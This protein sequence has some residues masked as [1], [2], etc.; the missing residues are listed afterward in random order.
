MEEMASESVWEEEYLYKHNN[1]AGEK[2]GCAREFMGFILFFLV[3]K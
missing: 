1:F 2:E 3:L